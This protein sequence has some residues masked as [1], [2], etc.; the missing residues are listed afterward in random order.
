MTDNTAMDET[1]NAIERSDEPVPTLNLRESLQADISNLKKGIK[2]AQEAVNDSQSSWEP[3][4]SPVTP[5]QANTLRRDLV[6]LKKDLEKKESE[7]ANLDR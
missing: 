1:M 7:F 5:E 3:A 6:F 2:S 4:H